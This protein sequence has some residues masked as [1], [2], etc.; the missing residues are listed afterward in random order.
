MVCFTYELNKL[1]TIKKLHTMTTFIS[2]VGY[3]FSA[4]GMLL[5]VTTGIY[6]LFFD[7]EEC[8]KL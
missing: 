8:E 3:S 1:K 7:K 2:F 5:V 4:I 6:G